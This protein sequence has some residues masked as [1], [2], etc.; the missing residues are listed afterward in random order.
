MVALRSIAHGPARFVLVTEATDAQGSERDCQRRVIDGVLKV[1]HRL[2]LHLNHDRH[3]FIAQHDETT[4][5]S[6]LERRRRSDSVKGSAA[7]GEVNA[8]L[9]DRP[10]TAAA[11]DGLTPTLLIPEGALEGDR[12][13]DL[14]CR[15]REL[16]LCAPSQ[17][18]RGCAHGC[19]PFRLEQDR[20][21]TRATREVWGI[22]EQLV[23]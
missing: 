12:R 19:I 1:A 10:S 18:P 8:K 22:V 5:S 23:P 20:S 17:L 9:L 3:S 21:R 7:T 16:T 15:C 13:A 2:N 4:A 11:A 14:S 6:K